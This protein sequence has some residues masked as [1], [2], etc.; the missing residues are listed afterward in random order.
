MTLVFFFGLRIDQ[1]VVEEYDNKLIQI[2]LPYAVYKIYEYRSSIGQL[3]RHD[4]ELKMFVSSL[5]RDFRNI[6]FVRSILKGAK[7]YG[8]FATSMAPGTRSMRNSTLRVGEMVPD[9]NLIKED[10]TKASLLCWILI[11]VLYAWK[12]WGRD[13]FARALIELDATCGLKGM[14][15]VAIPKFVG[16]GYTA[17]NILVEYEWKPPIFEEFEKPKSSSIVSNP[18]SVLEEDNGNY[19]DDLIDD[20]RKKV[21]ALPGKIG[22]CSDRKADFPKRNIVFSPETKV[23]YFDKDDMKFDN[24]GQGV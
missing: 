22:I 9:A 5:E 16:P 4:H 19:M 7:R 6:F 3:E 13:S 12:S 10:L 1:N 15:V 8:D 24:M 21:E 23:H 18:F 17:E 20:I 14:L 11:R 2:W